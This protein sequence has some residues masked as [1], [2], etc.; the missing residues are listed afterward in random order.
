MSRQAKKQNKKMD[1]CISLLI[2][3]IQINKSYQEYQ[4]YISE[5]TTTEKEQIS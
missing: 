1:K 5:G 4:F 3:C 2:N